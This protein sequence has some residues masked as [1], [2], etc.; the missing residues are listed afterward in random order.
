M[1]SF[2][3][4]YRGL[5]TGRSARRRSASVAPGAPAHAAPGGSQRSSGSSPIRSA[6]RPARIGRRRADDGGA[7][8]ARRACPDRVVDG[9][10]RP[11][12]RTTARR[13]AASSGSPAARRARP[14]SA[15]PSTCRPSPTRPTSC[16]PS[17]RRSA[18][19]RGR[20]GRRRHD[21]RQRPRPK[22]TSH[23]ATAA[24]R[25]RRRRAP[26]AASSA[27]STCLP[28]P[29]PGRPAVVEPRPRRTCPNASRR[30]TRS[31]GSSG[32]TST[33]TRLSTRAAGRAARL[34]RRRRPAGHRRRDRRPAASSA[35]PDS[36]LPYRPTVDHRRPGR[37]PERHPRRAARRRDGACRPCP[38]ELGRGP[39]P[40]DGRRPGRGRRT[41]LRLGLGDAARLRPDG[42]LDRQD[43]HRGRPVAPPPAGPDERRPHFVDDRH[44]RRARS[45]SCRRWRCRRSAACI[46][47]LVA[48]ILLIGPINY[49]VLRRLDR[50]EWAWFTMPILIVVFAV[51]AYGFGAAAAR[52]RRDRQRGRH[53]ARRP[54]RDRRARRRSTSAS[55]RRRAATYQVSVPG[56]ALLSSPINGD[57]FGGDGTARSLD[58]LQGDPA[59]VRDLAVGFG[60]LRTIRA[61]TAVAVPLDRGRPPARGRPPQGHGQERLDRARSS[62]PAVVL[63]GRRS[64]TSTTWS[65]APTATVDVADPVRTSSASRCRTRSS[66]RCS[67]V[68]ATMNA[69]RHARPY[70][71][72]TMVDQLTYDPNVR[73][74]QHALGRRSGRPGLGL[75][76]TCSRSRSRA[77]SRATSGTSCTTCRPM[78]AISGDDD[79]PLRPAP[80]DASSSPTPRS[81]TRTR[82]RINF[83]RG[84]GDARLPPDR[85][86]GNPDGDRA[87]DRA[88]LRRRHG[89]C[90]SNR[91]DRA[92]RRRSRRPVR[93]RRPPICAP[94]AFDGLARGRAVRHHQRRSWKRLPAP[95][96]R[97]P[98][99]AVADP[100]RYVDP[101]SGTRPRSDSSTTGCDSVGFSVDMSISGDGRMTAIVRTEGLVKRYDRTLAVAGIDLAVDAGRD[102]RPGR[103]ERR[104][105]DDDP[106]DARDAPAAV[107]RARPRS[108]AGRSPGTPTRS[109]ASS[110]SCRMRSGSTTT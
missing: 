19:D 64:R 41:A 15:S 36:L 76:T 63:G 28:E 104:R 45:P 49:L 109:V 37:E 54:G 68:T 3:S 55:S 11:P 44:A 53:R 80:L 31:T 43:R 20:P 13:S 89:G 110:A 73:V 100:A 95:R 7:H 12:R 96:Q 14:G 59:R 72:H 78:S 38:G 107:G 105:Q 62:S 10:L 81:S 60:S 99:Y 6:P 33:P 4:P 52:Q 24:R 77:R 67:S 9:D 2:L 88:E 90:R 98:R 86:R 34:G 51:G 46:A 83:G 97:R 22:F 102:L 69:G 25:R 18:P 103:A 65:R 106:A 74:D 21:G 87:R 93:T 85:L 1:P 39:G 94:A 8:P 48:Y 5:P 26:R 47:L 79:V 42:R 108:T 84:S 91:P 29:E 58:V 27:A 57:I 56:G 40:R 17:H 101:A 71:R 23:D 82:T 92:A 32:R 61:E 75:A 70:V 35:F 30:G 66:A 16:T 50:R